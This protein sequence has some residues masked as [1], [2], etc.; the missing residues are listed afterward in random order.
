MFDL[1]VIGEINPDL[2]LRD[3]DIVPVFGQAEKLVE[4]AKLTIGSSSVI[5]ACGAAR[6]GLKVSFIGLVGDDQFGRFMLRAMEER[7]IDTSACIVEPRVPT[8]MSVILGGSNDR[9]ILT[10][11]GTIPLL[12]AEQIDR[13]MLEQARHL[14][15]GSYFLLDNLRPE[16][17]EI[18]TDAR[19]RGLTT[20]LDTNWDPAEEWD[21]N[22]VLAHVN[23]F[24]P[25][26][27][28]VL[29][30][31]G[32]DDFTE[33]VD[34][35]S[36]QVPTLA[37][38]LGVQGGLARRGKESVNAPILPVKVVDTTGAGDSFNAGFLYG[39]LNNFSL[40]DSLVLACVC[41]SLSTRAAGGT[42]AQP[43]LEEALGAIEERDFKQ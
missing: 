17:P 22:A 39:Y 15:V 42:A 3:P 18:F 36:E 43:T 41:G 14:H 6:L 19:E 20:S 8:G 34:L 25:N 2:I 7:G 35:L 37:V 30:I 21:L 9:A 11:P 33:A 5:T 10:Y 23:V 26:K 4:D 28:E 27:N 12:E 29:L 13:T 31:T 1:L 32:E 24:F 40:K 38:K 16:L